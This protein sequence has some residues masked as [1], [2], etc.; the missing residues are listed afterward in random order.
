MQPSREK[1]MENIN[2]LFKSIIFINSCIAIHEEYK[3]YKGLYAEEI[4][5]AVTF[6]EV[7]KKATVYSIMMETAKLFEDRYST[8][9]IKK[10]INDCKHYQKLSDNAIKKHECFDDEQI[11]TEC[12]DNANISEIIKEFN[13]EYVSLS[14]IRKNLKDQRHNFF[15]HNNNDYSG[16]YTKL[17]DDFPLLC[18]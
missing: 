15:A 13:K 16:N 17:Q 18:Y 8:N 10:L 1:I 14:E 2:N 6:F 7:T 3:F 11:V 5:I 9:S 4:N 12:N